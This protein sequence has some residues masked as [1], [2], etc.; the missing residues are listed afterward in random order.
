MALTDDFNLHGKAAVLNV[1]LRG[2]PSLDGTGRYMVF[3]F[4]INLPK[5]LMEKS[6]G[7]DIHLLCKMEM[8]IAETG[9][10]VLE[11]T[12]RQSPEDILEQGIPP[13][14]TKEG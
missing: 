12:W 3:G 14:K 10:K 9:S 1:V 5:D 13:F 2:S 11:D 6:G 7:K 8:S 4:I